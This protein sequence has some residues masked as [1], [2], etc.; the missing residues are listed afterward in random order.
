VAIL[1]AVITASF[2]FRAALSGAGGTAGNPL[3]QY[4]A[5]AP[6]NSGK[7]SLTPATW[8]PGNVSF[9]QEDG[10]YEV[11]VLS[12]S[13]GK[14][15]ELK[16]DPATGLPLAQG[17]RPLSGFGP[18]LSPE[19]VKATLAGLLG[20][21]TVG[22]PA[23]SKDGGAYT[24]VLLNG[25]VVAKVKLDASG[26]TVAQEKEKERRFIRGHLVQPLGWVAALL[27]VSA[28]FYYSAKRSILTAVQVAEGPQRRIIARELRRAL[29]RHIIAAVVAIAIAFLHLSNFFGSIRLSLGWLTLLLMLAVAASGVF[30]RFFAGAPGVRRNWRR[31]HLPLT[32]VFF[33]VL[34]LHILQTI[35]LF[36]D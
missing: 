3:P 14:L 13:G 27:M 17:Q 12:Q 22:E 23:A 16:L 4:G 31:F 33:A 1:L 26:R 19:Q 9:E 24:P 34:A 20:R 15:F 8:S 18:V 5:T 11:T 32:Y 2:A 10:V 25:N 28:T 6:L 29:D 21:L 30:G 7:A 36:E 35:E